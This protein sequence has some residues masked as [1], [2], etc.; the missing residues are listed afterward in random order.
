MSAPERIQDFKLNH[1]M[2]QEDY[3]Q[4]LSLSLKLLQDSKDTSR[5]TERFIE[6]YDIIM[7]SACACHSIDEDVLNVCRDARSL[8]GASPGLALSA[9]DCFCQAGLYQQTMS[10]ILLFLSYRFAIPIVNRLARICGTWAS[11]QD[12]SEKRQALLAIEDVLTK[13]HAVKP[14]M[15]LNCLGLLA[16]D[17][18]ILQTV[19]DKRFNQLKQ[20][21]LDDSALQSESRNL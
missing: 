3:E 15:N 1:L 21:K 11:H 2:Y 10:S 4:A 17:Q 19:I 9:A 18:D 20:D 7:L 16:A 14:E 13:Q 6:L 5:G 12:V 8:C